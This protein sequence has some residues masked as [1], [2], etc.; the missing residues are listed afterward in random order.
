[1]EQLTWEEF[2]ENSVFGRFR[3]SKIWVTAPVSSARRLLRR[4]AK[5]LRVEAAVAAAVK[6]AAAK[7]RPAVDNGEELRANR[8]FL[9]SPGPQPFTTTTR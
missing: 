8:G 4:V 3:T 1:M 7:E 6:L 5:A 9:S 2:R